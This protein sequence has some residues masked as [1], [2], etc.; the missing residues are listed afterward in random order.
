M[1][2]AAPYE[3]GL[4]A[5]YLITPINKFSADHVLSG[6][7]F[8]SSDLSLKALAFI[9]RIPGELIVYKEDFEFSA[10]RGI[11]HLGTAE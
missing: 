6:L 8:S 2:T 11:T 10:V 5:F 9:R 3:L 1:L 7:F 4:L